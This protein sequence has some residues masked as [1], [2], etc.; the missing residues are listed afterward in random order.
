MSE[1]TLLMVCTAF[2]EEHT[3]AFDDARGEKFS[4]CPYCGAPMEFTV[5][6]DPGEVALVPVI[7]NEGA[8]AAASRVLRVDA[9]RVMSER[10]MRR[11]KNTLRRYASDLQTFVTFLSE[12]GFVEPQ[13]MEGMLMQLLTS[14]QGWS[15]VTA[16]V[17]HN[18]RD[19]LVWE[20]QLALSTVNVK[21]YTVR[22]FCGMAMEAGVLEPDELARI[23]AVQGYEGK[24]ARNLEERRGERRSGHKK[25]A[26]THIGADQVQELLSLRSATNAG[27]RNRAIMC[28]LL[29]HGFRVGE[30]AMLTIGNLSMKKEQVTVFRQKVDKVQT[31]NLSTTTVAALRDWLSARQVFAPDVPLFVRIHR[32]GRIS[33]GEKPI[34]E[35]GIRSVVGKLGESIGLGRLSPHDCRHY[36]ATYWSEKVDLFTLKTAGGWASIS[37]VDRYVSSGEIANEGMTD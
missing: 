11:S 30:V 32:G 27:R 36:W 16:A 2:P 8:I 22:T 7:N 17:V 25:G 24:E 13:H 3:L 21:L 14:L 5:G 18:Y 23:R 19:W 31:H 34:T 10:M 1:P 9:G 4:F 35:R 20:T 6:Y 33:I 15:S 28:L 12:T 29:H 37:T 26:P